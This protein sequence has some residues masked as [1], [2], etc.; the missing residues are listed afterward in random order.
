VGPVI[1]AFTTLWKSK[2]FVLTNV[3]ILVIETD[4]N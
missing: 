2:N 1:Y 4:F 3:T